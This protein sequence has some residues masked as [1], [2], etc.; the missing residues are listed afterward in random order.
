[1]ESPGDIFLLIKGYVSDH[2]LCQEPLIVWPGSCS[3]ETFDALCK[4]ARNEVNSYLE[5]DFGIN[6]SLLLPKNL[7]K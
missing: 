5:Y 3:Q 1:M 2:D 7:P 6:N 4:V